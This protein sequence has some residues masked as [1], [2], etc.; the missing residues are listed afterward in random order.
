[1]PMTSYEDKLLITPAKGKVQS[2]REK[3]RRLMQTALGLTQ[4]ALLRQLNP[5]LRGW[6]NYYRNG[7]AKATFGKLDYYVWRKLWRWITRRHPKKSQAWKKH[8]YFSAAGEK[9]LFSVRVRG[10]KGPSHVL[11]L[12][13]MASTTIERH[14]K[15]RGTANP[16]DPCYTQYFAQRRCFA[17][18]I[19]ST[20]RRTPTGSATLA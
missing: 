2:L 11:T 13:R 16:Y 6:A 9:G 10:K 4:E 19:R 1:M 20:N 18:R 14:I 3:I 12:Y 17:W 7:A 15:V 5:L 8:K